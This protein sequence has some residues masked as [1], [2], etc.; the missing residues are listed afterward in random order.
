MYSIEMGKYYIHRRK[1]VDIHTF[2]SGIYEYENDSLQAHTCVLYNWVSFVCMYVRIC[3]Y[4]VCMYENAY[5]CLNV[6]VI[7]I[8]IIITEF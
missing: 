1:F 4:I 7:A 3:I 2:I 8:T 5:V 6:K